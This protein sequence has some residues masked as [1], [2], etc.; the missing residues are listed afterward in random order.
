TNGGGKKD[1]VIEFD[2][3]TVKR[4]RQKRPLLDKV[5]FSVNSNEILGFAGVGGNGLGVIEAVLGG[6]LHPSEGKILHR[7]K[8]ITKLNIRKLRNQ[9]LSFVPADRVNVGSA[10]EATL[11]ENMI[12]NVRNEYFSFNYQKLTRKNKI[13]ED[14][15]LWLKKYS[16]DAPDLKQKVFTLS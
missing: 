15:N 4:R 5:S 11:E 8:D 7:G 1:N 12:I 13:K 14:I 6:F 9:G 2:N 10:S 16:L 3:V